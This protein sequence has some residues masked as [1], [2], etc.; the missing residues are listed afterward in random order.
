MNQP[1]VTAMR[2][3]YVNRAKRPTGVPARTRQVLTSIYPYS[4]Y[5]YIQLKAFLMTTAFLDVLLLKD[6]ML[7]A[8]TSHAQSMDFISTHRGRMYWTA[9][10]HFELCMYVFW[11][12]L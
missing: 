9:I 10:W 1:V 5:S 3:D 2:D 8:W 6:Y 7:N 12:F 11:T 4:G